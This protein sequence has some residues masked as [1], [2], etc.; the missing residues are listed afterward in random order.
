[1]RVVGVVGVEVRRDEDGVVPGLLAVEEDVVVLGGIE[2]EVRQLVQGGIFVPDLVY[3][4]DKVLDMARPLPVP[5]LVLVDLG[6]LV[7]DGRAAFAARGVLAELVAVVDAVGRRECGRQREPLR[8]PFAIR[9]GC[10]DEPPADDRRLRSARPYGGAQLLRRG[11]APLS[12]LLRDERVI[13]A[14]QAAGLPPNWRMW[15]RMSWVLAKKLGRMY[16][17]GQSFVS[18]VRYSTISALWLRQV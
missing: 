14:E 10:L 9:R 2:L 18:S 17:F 6:V 13:Q 15:G 3:P 5:D 7:V 1:M 4:P 8:G 16:S 11:A 12:E